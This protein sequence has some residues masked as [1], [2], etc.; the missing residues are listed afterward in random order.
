[1]LLLF[2]LMMTSVALCPVSGFAFPTTLLEHAMSNIVPM[3]ESV[4]DLSNMPQDVLSPFTSVALS[5]TTLFEMDDAQIRAA[6][7]STSTP[8]PSSDAASIDFVA[9]ALRILTAFTTYFGLVLVTDKPKGELFFDEPER[10]LRVAPSS[11]EGAGLGLYVAETLPKGTKLGTYP[12][13]VV[14]LEPHLSKLNQHPHCEAYIWRFSD[15]QMVI[16]PTN[17]VGILDD[18]CVGG[19]PNTFFSEWFF[20]NFP[21]NI[22]SGIVSPPVPTMLCR[23]NEPPLGKDVNVVTDEDRETRTVVFSLERDVYAGEELFIDYGLSYD[24]SRY[25]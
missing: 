17:P 10:Y 7:M 13:I 21:G 19:N 9:W 23:I 12:G 1:M 24:R 4:S 6:A 3:K 2:V 18:L 16:D 8:L 5:S 11:V 22:L 25:G 15:S 20:G 14:P